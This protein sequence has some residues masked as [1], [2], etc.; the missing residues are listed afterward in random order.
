M[1]GNSGMPAV[2]AFVDTNVLLYAIDT[3]PAQAGKMSKAE[4]LLTSVNWAW[5]AQVAAEFVASNTSS[6]RRQPLTLAEAERWLHSWRKFPLTAIDF[7]TVTKAIAT[8]WRIAYYDAQILA[9]AKQLGCQTVYSE[10]LNDGQDY[11][12]VTVIN[13]FRP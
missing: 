9:A 10:D 12:G 11:G 3:D 13:P 1:T 8:R 5:S 2:D 7:E 6:R 4:Q